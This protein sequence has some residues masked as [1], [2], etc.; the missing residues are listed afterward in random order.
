MADIISDL[1]GF[2]LTEALAAEIDLILAETGMD[3]VFHMMDVVAADYLGNGNG[4]GS[5]T[6]KAPRVKWGGADLLA[7]RTEGVAGSPTA[8]TTGSATVVEG[9]QYFQYSASQEA[10]AK[11]AA[12]MQ[13]LGDPRALAMESLKKFDGRLL[14]MYAAISSGFTGNLV[15]KTGLAITVDD[16]YAAHDKLDAAHADGDRILLV[17]PGANGWGN[18]KKDLRTES[19][20]V[21]SRD[22]NTLSLI[23]QFGSNYKGRFADTHIITT[24]N[25]ATTGGDVFS[26]LFARGAYKWRD[27]MPALNGANPIINVGN[28]VVIELDRTPNAGLNNVHFHAM[29]GVAEGQDG[30]G[31]SIRHLA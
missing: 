31:A 18:I 27:S 5:A 3:G 20:T 24:T 17:A 30:A 6:T 12:I 7:P 9:P 22:P 1:V 21:L 2:N 8:L 25:L 26:V 10:H 29:I 16:F 23:N 11:L 4:T 14:Q 13:L 28:R 19:G 15:N